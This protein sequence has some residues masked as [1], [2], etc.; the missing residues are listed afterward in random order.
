[1]PTI[2]LASCNFLAAQ[3][4]PTLTAAGRGQGPRPLLFQPTIQP[5]KNDV[6]YDLQVF[7]QS[8]RCSKLCCHGRGR[9]DCQNT[10]KSYKTSFFVGWIVGWKS[11]GRGPC[12][13][14]AA[15]NVGSRCAARKL[16]DAR[17]MVGIS[18]ACQEDSEAGFEP[19][20]FGL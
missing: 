14:P 20:T 9:G 17:G 15:V 12:P 16:H 13:L 18:T 7:W 5:T 11:R 1:M 19:P 3:R 8:P 10:C 4:D 6:L 2:P